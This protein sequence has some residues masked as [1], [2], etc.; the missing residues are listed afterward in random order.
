MY[1][2][3]SYSAVKFKFRFYEGFAELKSKM[4]WYYVFNVQSESEVFINYDSY[5]SLCFE[6]C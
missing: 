5:N 2:K 6:F 4:R 1:P 3:T